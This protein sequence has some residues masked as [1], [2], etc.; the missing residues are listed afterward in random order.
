[1]SNDNGSNYYNIPSAPKME[2]VDDFNLVYTGK[3]ICSIHKDNKK[4]T[5]YVTIFHCPN[6]NGRCETPRV[7]SK[8]VLPNEY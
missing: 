5:N 3:R 4:V 6:P 2:T 1:M 8:A 7:I